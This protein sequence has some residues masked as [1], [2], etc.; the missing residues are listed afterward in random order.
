MMQVYYDMI[1]KQKFTFIYQFITFI[2]D[3]YQIKSK[4]EYI[5]FSTTLFYAIEHI[6]G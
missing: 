2:F 6:M 3:E 4:R 1:D 5:S